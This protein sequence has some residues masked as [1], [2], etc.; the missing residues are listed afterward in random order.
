MDLKGLA[1][2]IKRTR[3]ETTL[4]T[5][6]PIDGFPLEASSKS[7]SMRCPFCGWPNK[8]KIRTGGTNA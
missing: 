7:Q 1:K 2:L 8:G 6:C 5:T 3:T 4:A